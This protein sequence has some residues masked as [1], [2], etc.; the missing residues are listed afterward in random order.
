[1]QH[2][3]P[4]FFREWVSTLSA[5]EADQLWSWMEG[6]EAPEEFIDLVATQVELQDGGSIR[7]LVKTTKK[8]GKKRV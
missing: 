2:Q 7:T 1:M 3:I 8:K 5:E 6:I 4:P